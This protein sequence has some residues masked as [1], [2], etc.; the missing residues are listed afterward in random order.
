MNENKKNSKI[1]YKLAIRY[2]L[3]GFPHINNRSF[4]TIRKRP[5]IAATWLL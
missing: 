4:K 2:Y 1:I 3:M 5:D